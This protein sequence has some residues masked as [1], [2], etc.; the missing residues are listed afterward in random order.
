MGRANQPKHRQQ[1]KLKR[2]QNTRASYDRVLIV[3]E[4]RKT[5]P[6]YFGDIKRKYRLHSANIQILPSTG[7]SPMQV[8]QYAEHIFKN[9]DL[10]N[11]ISKR[12]FDRVYAV[13]DRDTHSSYN[14]ALVKAA[15]LDRKLENDDRQRIEFQAIPSNPCFE[16]WL[17]LH[18]QDA[19]GLITSADALTQLRTHL[20][21]YAKSTPNI[22]SQTQ[23]HL[24]DAY[25]RA[26]QLRLL[27]SPTST[28]HSYTEIDK[29]VKLLTNLTLAS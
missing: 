24:A 17:L 18:Y 26:D 29:V 7:T 12:A 2:K 5:E 20:P 6:S 23:H 19:F 22:L 11:S 25:T 10:S 21:G 16:L 1:N 8:V 28:S 14:N 27:S 9:G 3:C 4:G 15:R 13:F